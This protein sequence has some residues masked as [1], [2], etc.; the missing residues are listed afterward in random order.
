MDE[1]VQFDF[2]VTIMPNFLEV[3]SHMFKLRTISMIYVCQIYEIM[4]KGVCVWWG[5]G[6]ALAR[7]HACPQV[8]GLS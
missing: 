8:F 3:Y 5:G 1:V 2:W 6:R 4:P 7:A